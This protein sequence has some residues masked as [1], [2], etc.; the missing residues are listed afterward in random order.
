MRLTAVDGHEFDAYEAHPESA[1]ASIVV[2]QEIFGVNAHIRSVTDRFAALGYR[3]V[4]PAIF[5]RVEPGVELEYTAE[6]IAQGRTMA[7]EVRWQPA[8]SDIAAVVAHVAGTGP[9]AVI[10]YCFG[11]SLAWLSANELPI[12]AAVGYY[13]GQVVEFIDRAPLVPTMLHFGALDHAIPLDGV[14]SIAADHPSVAVHIY[15]HAEH[16][17]NCDARGSFNPVA[18]TIAMGRTL[19]FLLDAGVRP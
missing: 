3:A 18:A 4:A 12:A 13:G 11:G 15:D 1:S 2:V 16:G 19:E 6:G 14:A 9:V 17:F 10:G 8:M 7:M 5:D